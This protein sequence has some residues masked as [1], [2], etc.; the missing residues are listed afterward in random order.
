MRNIIKILKMKKIFESFKESIL[1][2]AKVSRIWQHIESDKTFGVISPYRA[3]YSEDENL[4]RYAELKKLV[5]TAKYG[6]IEMIGGFDE[7]GTTVEEKS[8]FIPQVDKDKDTLIEWGK[9]FDQY[10]VLYKDA[11]EFVEIGTNLQAGIGDI[12]TNFI[13][14]GWDKNMTFNSE[15][16]KQF[17]SVIAKGSHKTRKFLFNIKEYLYELESLS[18]NERV[19]GKKTIQEQ[20]RIQLL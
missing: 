10:S 11:N 7:E 2:E 6:F 1:N 18:F 14:K 19:Y 3:E 15:L 13:Q 12:K 8:L 9:K 16:I 20:D 17:F 5:R 4:K